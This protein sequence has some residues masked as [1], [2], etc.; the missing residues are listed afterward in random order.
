MKVL[1]AAMNCDPL[2]NLLFLDIETTG[3]FGGGTVPFLIGLGAWKEG[4]FHLTQFLLRRGDDEEVMLSEVARFVSE[5]EVLVTFNGKAFDVPIL[6]SRSVL[7]GLRFPAPKT[8]LDLYHLAR[9]MGK[10][11]P[12]RGSLDDSCR[13]FLNVVREGDV[14]GRLIPALYFM[15]L[16]E[17]DPDILSSA[18]EHNRLDVLDMV[19]LLMR[20]GKILEGESTDAAAL[21]GAGRLHYRKGNLDLAQKCLRESFQKGHKDTLLADILRKQG[22][23]QG[24]KAIWESALRDETAGAKEYLWLARYYELQE[25]DLEK[26][27][28]LIEEALQKCPKPAPPALLSRRRR[29]YRMLKRLGR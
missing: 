26:A 15:Y 24:A 6:Q 1:R 9:N 13:R 7:M 3:L 22:D 23:W 2:E 18:L 25:N 4:E 20:F 10:K 16:K 28:A 8:H 29:L 12:Y 27:V 21:K 5:Y 19:L 11:H 14:P 17:G